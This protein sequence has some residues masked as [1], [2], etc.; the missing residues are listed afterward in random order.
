[1]RSGED[2]LA[3]VRSG[4]RSHVDDVVRGLHHL[5]IMLHHD[6]GVT[7]IAQLFQHLDQLQRVAR[8]QADAGLV[9]DVHAAHQAAAERGG[10]IDALCFATAEGV[11]AALQGEVSHTHVHEVRKPVADL[12][13]QPRGDLLVLVVQ[14]QVTEELRTLRDRHARQF[15]DVLA[16][17]LHVPR[18]GLQTGAVAYRAGG[19]PAEAAAQHTVLDL[20]A[21]LF[22]ILEEPIDAVQTTRA[23]PEQITLLVREVVDG[24]VDGE[25]VLR[26]VADEVVFP[27][28]QLFASPWCYGIVVQA[29]ALVRDHQVVVDADDVAVPFALR[30][31]THGIIE[32]EEVGDGFLE[33]DAVQFEL[34]VEP[35]LTGRALLVLAQQDQFTLPLEEAALGTIR[36]A[37]VVLLVARGDR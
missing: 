20:V 29:Q 9:Q 27:L 3:A 36:C 24:T 25:I 19:L 16:S 30:A 35:K 7:Q 21:L 34:V 26:A 37:A 13:Q 18:L 17:D 5:L 31:S 4:H 8:V 33:G 10:Q 6:H 23:F 12:L 15:G 1:M 11:A 2:H 22:H 32:A 28:A 14:L